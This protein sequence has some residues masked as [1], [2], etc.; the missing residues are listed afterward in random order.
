[1]AD[2]PDPP[3]AANIRGLARYYNSVTEKGRAGVS[4]IGSLVHYSSSQP[5]CV[6]ISLCLPGCQDHI[7]CHGVG[8]LVFEIEAI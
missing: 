7:S 6:I 2:G 5:K 4:M 8:V 1:M 3:E